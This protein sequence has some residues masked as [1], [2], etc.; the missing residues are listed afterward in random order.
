MKGFRKLLVPL[1]GSRL[2]EAVLP[3][4]HLLAERFGATVS[5][6]HVMEQ[7]APETIHGERHLDNLKEAE[8]YLNGVASECDCQASSVEIHVH[9]NQERD[10]VA[11][12]IGHAREFEADLIILATHGWGGM[13]DLLVGSIAQ[14]VLRRGVLPVLL[15]RPTPSG[16]APPFEGKRILVPLDGKQAHDGVV[17]P[18]VERVAEALGS[19]LHLL[20]VVPTLSTMPRNQAPVNTLSPSATAAAL[21]MEEDEGREYLARLAGEMMEKKITVSAE[22]RRGD[23]ASSVVDVVREIDP[24]LIVMATH[25]RAGLGAFW[26]ASVGSKILARIQQPL[27]MVRVPE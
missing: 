1:D 17:L 18:V 4:T 24:D 27:L 19:S 3:A 13:R 6:L 11:S 15:I 10:V 9:P 23:A 5:L 16:G 21:D 12:I 25:G 8:E 14:Q 26:S 20:L 22:V 2:A 7:G